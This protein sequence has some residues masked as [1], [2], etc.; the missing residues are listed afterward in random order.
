VPRIWRNIFQASESVRADNAAARNKTTATRN[1]TTAT[2]NKTTATRNK[3]T[4]AVTDNTQAANIHC[5]P[6]EREF[7]SDLTK[8]PVI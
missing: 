6:R 5:N 3:T 1:K 4:W 2:R 7:T 8:S